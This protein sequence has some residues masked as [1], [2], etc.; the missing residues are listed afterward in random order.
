M[1]YFLIGL[2]VWFA[3][4]WLPQFVRSWINKIRFSIAKK[5]AGE[6]DKWAFEV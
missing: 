1:K 4:A 5:R 2:A 3:L 6:D